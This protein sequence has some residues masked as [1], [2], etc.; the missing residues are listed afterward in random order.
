M[1][2]VL[3]SFGHNWYIYEF[4]IYVFP[5]N[6][7]RFPRKHVVCISLFCWV[8]R[9]KLT[10]LSSCP[11]WGSQKKC[12][13]PWFQHHRRS[14]SANHHV[15][16]NYLHTVTIW[17]IFSKIKMKFLFPNHFSQDPVL[18][19]SS[20]LI[21]AKSHQLPQHPH[22][23]S[24]TGDYQEYYCNPDSYWIKICFRLIG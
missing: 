14:W 20:G 4:L 21:H 24:R 5:I 3:S 23:S 22:H 13:Y 15:Q 2:F 10:Y 17:R 6:D 18:G 7:I 1:I 11:Y 8:Y 16:V 19:S 12:P 9:F